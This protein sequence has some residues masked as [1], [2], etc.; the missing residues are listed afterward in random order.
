MIPVELSRPVKA[1]QI[2]SAP[3][4]V[5]VEADAGERAALMKR[6]D[7]VALDSLGAELSVRRE[8]AGIRVTGQVK[9]RA[10]QAC[11]VSGEPV[12]TA[13]DTPLDL[14]FA[15]ESEPAPD[16]E[17]EL[18]DSDC[19]VVPFDGQ[20][21]DLGEAVAQ[22]LGLALDPY[23]RAAGPAVDEVRQFLT[24]EED[25]IAARSPFAALKKP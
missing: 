8:A 6:F 5:S 13:I 9:G 4:L 7:L 20:S 21:V 25:M 23:P 19:D 16:D 24:S 2:G 10:A 14:L 3:R 18:S 11:V 15:A 17:I 12:P 1:D 22:T